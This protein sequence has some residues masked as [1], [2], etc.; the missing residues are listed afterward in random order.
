MLFSRSQCLSLG[1]GRP[2]GTPQGLH[3]L[4]NPPPRRHIEKSHIPGNLNTIHFIYIAV[5]CFIY[6]S[7]SVFAYTRAGKH[8]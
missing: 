1:N 2:V 8:I 7:S 3:I 4:Q 6:I 5:T